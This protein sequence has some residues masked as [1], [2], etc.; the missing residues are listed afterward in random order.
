MN[1]TTTKIQLIEGNWADPMYYYICI[2]IPYNKMPSNEIPKQPKSYKLSQISIHIK[3]I[4]NRNQFSKG[5]VQL[6]QLTTT[7]T[8]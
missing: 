3:L 7:V 4:K 1:R 5:R 8:F 6:Q 2:N